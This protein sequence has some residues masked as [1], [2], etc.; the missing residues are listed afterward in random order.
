[1]LKYLKQ[2]TLQYLPISLNYMARKNVMVTKLLQAMAG[3]ENM[4]SEINEIIKQNT[5]KVYYSDD[6]IDYKLLLKVVSDYKITLDSLTPINSGMVAIVFSGKDMDNKRVIVKM[7]RKNIYQR[8]KSGYIQFARIYK[9]IRILTYPFSYFNEILL[10][11]K[12]FIDTKDYILT[13][14][15]FDDE[16]IAIETTKDMIEQYTKELV[17]PRVYNNAKDKIGTEFIIMEFIEGTTCYNIEDRYREQ[18]CEILFKYTWL[19][20][21]FASIYHADLHPGNILCIPNGDTC[22]VGIIDFGMNIKATENVRQFA[23]GG[24]NLLIEN[25]KGNKDKFDLI[26]YCKN[27]TIPPL[28][29]DTFTKEVYNNLNSIFI[30][31]VINISNGKLS[32]KSFQYALKDIR[33]VIKSNSILLSN[34]TVKYAMSLSM[35]RSSAMLLVS[36]KNKLSQILKKSLKEV[37]SY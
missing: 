30:E 10:N 33:T 24:L 32:E 22:K 9:L 7:K 18:T 14:C 5:D 4:P 37:M 12:S 1:M 13:Q 23:H 3:I 31:I 2:L 35:A 28:E 29:I 19:S 34:D 8:I 27:A 25:E 26:K 11:I 20:T 6:E 15:N 21:Y 36:D 16:I 17:I